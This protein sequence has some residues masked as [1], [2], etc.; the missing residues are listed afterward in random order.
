M[1][2][3]DRLVDELM[4]HCDQ[5]MEGQA[6]LREKLLDLVTQVRT[7]KERVAELEL[8]GNE[9]FCIEN[10]PKPYKGNSTHLEC[11]KYYINNFKKFYWWKFLFFFTTF[12]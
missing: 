10:C 11:K 3:V 2:K 4:R 9:K 8:E 5:G 7:L 6:A 12:L 1:G